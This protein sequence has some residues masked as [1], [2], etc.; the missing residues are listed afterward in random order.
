MGD[1]FYAT[2]NEPYPPGDE[3]EFEQ[4]ELRD[5]DGFVYY[6]GY[7]CFCGEQGYKLPEDA[8]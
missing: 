8:E 1:V 7:S 6:E 5:E 3:H 4:Y 2:A